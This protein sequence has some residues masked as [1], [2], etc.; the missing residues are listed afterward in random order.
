MTMSLICGVAGA[1]VNG[2]WCWWAP[3]VG[4]GVGGCGRRQSDGGLPKS[5]A[6]VRDIP[7]RYRGLAAAP[8]AELRAVLRAAV[9][10]AGWRRRLSVVTGLSG[11]DYSEPAVELL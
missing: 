6:T 9:G 2:C 7:A 4:V 5:L 8:P 3:G 1:G 10:G 11:P